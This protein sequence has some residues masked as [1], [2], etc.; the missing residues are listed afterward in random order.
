M[1]C[2]QVFS[3]GLSQIAWFQCVGSR[4]LNR[5]DN[6][7]CSSVCCMYAIKEAV[8]AKEHSGDDL[9]CTIFYMDMRT[10]GKDFERFYERAKESGVRFMLNC[11]KWLEGD[12]DEILIETKIYATNL[13]NVTAQQSKTVS[14]FTIYILPG[15][16]LLIGLAVYLRRRNL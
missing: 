8:I 10:H 13:I 4:D 1:D 5:C 11:F 3:G 15:L 9:E 6:A 2:L 12:T 16:I 14:I 7:Y